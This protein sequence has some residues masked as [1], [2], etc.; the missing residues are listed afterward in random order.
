MD[1]FNN[2]DNNPFESGSGDWKPVESENTPNQ[3]AQEVGGDS[4]P[5]DQP[6]DYGIY[7]EEQTP[8]QQPKKKPQGLAI[9]SMVLG[10][11]GLV[12]VNCCCFCY[13]LIE[14]CVIAGIMGVVGLVLGI[15]TLAKNGK[16]GKAI[17]GV[18]MCSITL[19][20]AL[21]Y[22]VSS[23]LF[24]GEL[25]EQL[26]EMYPEIFEEYSDLYPGGG[27]GDM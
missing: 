8:N 1:E 12:F 20:C 11:V 2:R 18:I 23:I 24:L 13:G 19:L 25:I 4:Q 6:F 15:V 17:A 7:M 27:Y 3:E 10:I 14:T 5:G 9:A 16:N 21:V 26:K 22:A